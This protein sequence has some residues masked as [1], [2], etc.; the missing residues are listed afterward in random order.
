MQPPRLP[1]C[2]GA[3]IQPCNSIAR[4]DAAQQIAQDL[5]ASGSTVRVWQVEAALELLAEG[6]TIPFIARYRKERTG[7]LNEIQ[8]RSIFEQNAYIEELAARKK[9]VL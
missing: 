3:K 2:F 6:A 1:P 4:M 8:L 5:S 9:T 7:E